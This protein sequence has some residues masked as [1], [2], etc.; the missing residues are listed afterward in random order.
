M[1]SAVAADPDRTLR[2]LPSGRQDWTGGGARKRST[3]NADQRRMGMG[4][5]GHPR[6]RVMA[7]LAMGCCLCLTL[8]GCA[9]ASGFFGLRVTGP[10]AYDA[11]TEPPLAM[12]PSFHRLPRPRPGEP[13]TQRTDSAKSAE[14]L[15]DP[16]AILNSRQPHMTPGQKAFLQA[17]GPAPRHVA[18]DLDRDHGP[19]VIVDAEAEWRRIQEDAA[20]GKPVTAGE[21]PVIKRGG[22]GFL[23]SLASWL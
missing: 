17:A 18:A 11:A 19:S 15:L 4:A 8:A 7:R 21:T 3:D 13:P 23:R 1:R 6:Y 2:S 14:A 10:N 9:A 20:L 12:P 5:L 22:E 16:Q